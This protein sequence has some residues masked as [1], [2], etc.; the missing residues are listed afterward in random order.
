M[1]KNS[2]EQVPLPKTLAEVP[3]IHETR[4]ITITTREQIKSLVER[5]LV[6][7]CEIFWDK[8]IK[9]YESSA[10]AWNIKTGFCYIK[11][12]FD[13]LSEE[14]KKIA[15]LS[16]ELYDELG[17]KTIVTLNIPVLQTTSED[18]LSQKAITIAETFKAQRATW[19]SSTTLDEQL[20]YYEQRYGEKYPAQV[21]KEK[22]RLS[23]PG[24]WEEECKN[25]G[26]YF[27]KF[28]GRAY[29]SQELCDKDQAEVG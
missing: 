20:E 21:V 13:S 3:A 18:E 29:A 15:E 27:D 9:T 6:T 19:I 24:A 2:L 11:L 8:N 26:Y 23:R 17:E 12:D 1:G 5:P 16:G 28:S 14:N 7:A 25:L 10:N 4:G 22:E